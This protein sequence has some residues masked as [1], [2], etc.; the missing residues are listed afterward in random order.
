MSSLITTLDGILNRRVALEQPAEGF[1]V[2][3]DTVLLASAVPALAGQR[4]LDLG[5]GVGGAML[6]LACRVPGV[7]VEGV[8]IQAALARLG[9]ANIGRNAFDA[10]LSVREGDVMRLPAVWR[11]AFDHVMM[12][13]P[14]HD[15]A[16]H[17]ASANA[18]K[19]R[20]N[21]EDEG[22]LPQWIAS[23]AQAL[24][25]GGCLTLI[26]RADR[27]DELCVH[28]R[29]AFGAVAVKPI[30]PKAAVAPKRVILRAT[31]GGAEVA[32]TRPPLVLHNAD[33]SYTTEADALLRDMAAMAF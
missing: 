32:S 11:E 23:A 7:A 16:R 15:A 4:V 5:C 29:G 8:E 31:K 9:A 1:R 27:A 13:P 30:L 12:N 25:T 14:Y 10:A 2:A 18:I 19:R 24:K 22:D 6:A 26:H 21:T 33:G 17:D 20:A 3:V 28:L